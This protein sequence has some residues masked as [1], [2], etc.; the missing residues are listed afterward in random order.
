MCGFR[1][2]GPQRKVLFIPDIDRWEDWDVL[3]VRV[4]DEIA[5]ADIAYLDGTFFSGDELPGR[6]M[7][8][9]PHPTIASSMTRFEALPAVE[10][11]KIR[12]IH[13]NWSNPARFADS[14]ARREI[15]AKGFGVAEE[16]ESVA[17]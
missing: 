6:D 15:E 1:I 17:L 7:S 10:R 3:G 9:V 14:S 4:D 12:F 16:G 13:L 11:A 5:R 2:E 8:K